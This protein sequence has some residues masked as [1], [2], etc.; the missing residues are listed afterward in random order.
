MAIRLSTHEMDETA[1]ASFNHHTSTNGIGD[2]NEIGQQSGR[3]Q[4]S[5]HWIPTF[6]EAPSPKTISSIVRRI[7]ALILCLVSKP[8]IIA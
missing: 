8:K 6:K 3:S 5:P 7:R 1:T 2:G 4:K